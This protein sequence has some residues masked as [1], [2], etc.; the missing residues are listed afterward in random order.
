ME[1]LLNSMQQSQ[2]DPKSTYLILS[3]QIFPATKELR[4][5][6][7]QKFEAIPFT[8]ESPPYDDINSE[9]LYVEQS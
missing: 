8:M 1:K 3:F 9:W 2:C 4:Q 5:I 6:F 7:S